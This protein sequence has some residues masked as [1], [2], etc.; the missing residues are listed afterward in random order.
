MKV[1]IGEG[2]EKKTWQIDFEK[3]VPC[4]Q[5]NCQG[6]AELAFVAHEGLDEDDREGPF[7]Y[8]LKETTGQAGEL[9]LHDRCAVAVYFCRVCLKVTAKAYQG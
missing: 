4:V 3:E 8:E 2:A 9:W 6:T 7:V 1:L 5:A